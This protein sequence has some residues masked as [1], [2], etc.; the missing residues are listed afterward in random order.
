M[1]GPAAA[2]DVNC[3]TASGSLN[4]DGSADTPFL[5]SSKEDLQEF[6]DNNAPGKNYW[7]ANVYVEMTANIDMG[8]C[9]WSTAIA[10]APTAYFGKFDG[11]GFV[12]SG[13]SVNDTTGAQ[14][15]GL[16]G[17]A[18]TGAEISNLTFTGNV[19]GGS[20]NQVGG[21][22]GGAFNDSAY[23]NVHVSGT[24]SG[25]TYV[26][27]LIGYASTTGVITGS[28]AS[29]DVTGTGNDVGGLLGLLQGP[30]VSNTFATGD[31]QGASNVG[32][33]V[34]SYSSGSIATSYASGAVTASSNGGGLV[35]GS[36]TVTATTAYWDTDVSVATSRGGTGKTTAELQDISTFPTPT[37][38]IAS[39]YDASYTWGIC[40]AVNDG[41]PF[42]TGA[43]SSDPCASGN[44]GTTGSAP[45]A[46]YTFIFKLP[47]GR[48]CTSISPVTVI[49]GEKYTLPGVDADC[50]T[51][52]G[53]TVSGWT[54]PVPVGFT[55]AGSEYL[56]F[57]P[58]HVVDV[59]DSQQFTVVPFEPVLSLILDSNVGVD[60]TCEPTDATFVDESHQLEYSWI[61][62]VDVSMAR[63]PVQAACQPPGYTL[64]GW[65]TAADGS[66]TMF[67]PG[68]GVPSSWATDKTNRYR[69]FAIW[70][71]A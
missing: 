11:N 59:S 51:M 9:I 42:L 36:S 10:K 63:L 6:R 18:G 33:L 52:P 62:R 65:N 68:S 58:G 5:I 26:G 1:A 37:W 25:A 39:G 67:E 28:S 31:V 38:S 7:A 44:G 71:P 54:I 48:T 30:T 45:P 34:G 8:G 49:D 13:L 53:A 57:S 70:A 32:G 16:F 2:A 61:P 47:D 43:Y 14:Y 56:P 15:V 41:Y 12:I 46:R 22:I 23:S 24:V 21:L 66:G 4:G 60:Q 17:Y 3:P 27:G 69:L 29:G 19:T 55:G 20:S 64:T 40:S 35:G 50:R